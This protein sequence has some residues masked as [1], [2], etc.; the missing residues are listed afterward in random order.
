MEDKTRK[1]GLK[2]YLKIWMEVEPYCAEIV[3]VREYLDRVDGA[4]KFIN[5]TYKLDYL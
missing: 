3:K 2:Y 1:M 5:I 4:H